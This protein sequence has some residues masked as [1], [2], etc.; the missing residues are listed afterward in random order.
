MLVD[1]ACSNEMEEDKLKDVIAQ[2]VYT[3]PY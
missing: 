2:H 3:Y 1:P